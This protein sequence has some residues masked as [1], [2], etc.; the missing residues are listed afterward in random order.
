MSMPPPAKPKIYHITH[1]DNLAGIVTSG[2]IMSDAGRSREGIVNMNVGMPP[3]KQRRRGLPVTPHPGRKVG[4]FVPFYFCPRSIMLYML[5]KG[6]HPE[7]DYTGGQRPIIHLQCDLHEVVDHA[8]AA[9]H[10]W[11][12]TTSNAGA[13]YTKFFSDLDDLDQVNWEAVRASD[14]R[15]PEIKEGKQAEFLFHDTF[16]W[17]LVERIG[18]IDREA[19]D[20]ATSLL[21][22]ADH[23][24]P[25]RVSPQWYYWGG[26]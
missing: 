15:S 25:I 22:G 8:D 1:L 23:S 5:H 20:G 24:P 3:I 6:N 2:G 16:P 19:F 9:R 11:A 12:F 4:D 13:R 17:R 14:F 26:V 7:L 18:V 21:Q 10:P